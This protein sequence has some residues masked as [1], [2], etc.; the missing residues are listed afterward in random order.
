EPHPSPINGFNAAN[1][2]PAV[3]PMPAQ[4]GNNPGDMKRL[5]NE[6]HESGS[7]SGPAWASLLIQPQT[8]DQPSTQNTPR[9]STSHSAEDMGNNSDSAD[10]V[11]AKI[12]EPQQPSSF[13]ALA[14]P[15]DQQTSERPGIQNMPRKRES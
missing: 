15:P 3:R 13:R 14:R 6:K 12:R 5:A 10:A 4:P 9:D 11:G 7:S 8:S 2:E 1:A